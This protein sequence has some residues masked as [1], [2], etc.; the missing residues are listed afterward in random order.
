MNAYVKITYADGSQTRLTALGNPRRECINT[1]MR[2][3]RREPSQGEI[4]SVEF[5]AEGGAA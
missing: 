2:E 5:F 1:L 3:A 4:V